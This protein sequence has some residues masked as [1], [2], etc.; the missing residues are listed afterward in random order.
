MGGGGEEELRGIVKA[1]TCF[2]HHEGSLNI[3]KY[4]TN[5]TELCHNYYYHKSYKVGKRAIMIITLH[6]FPMVFPHG[7]G[8]F[9]I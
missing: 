8:Y 5:V 3:T 7:S 9:T 6:W 1:I 2:K 4:H